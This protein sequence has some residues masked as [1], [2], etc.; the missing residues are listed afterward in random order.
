MTRLILYTR[1]G[2]GFCKTKQ[3]IDK[4][5]AA[6]LNYRRPRFDSSPASRP[7]LSWRKSITQLRKTRH[8]ADEEFHE[9]Y[10]NIAMYCN[11]SS[12]PVREESHQRIENTKKIDKENGRVVQDMSFLYLSF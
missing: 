7:C 2:G 6:C 4:Q 11:N 1:S 5:G 3:D 8:P 10:S 9:V 12:L